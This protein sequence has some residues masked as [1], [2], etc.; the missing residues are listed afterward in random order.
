MENYFIAKNKV[1]RAKKKLFKFS[2]I[3]LDKY[4]KLLCDIHSH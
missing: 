3:N 2:D 4:Y 1:L